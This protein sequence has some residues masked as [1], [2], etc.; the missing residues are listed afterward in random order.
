[1]PHPSALAVEH[2]D[3]LAR[4]GV[5]H[6]EAALSSRAARAATAGGPRPAVPLLGKPRWPPP[7]FA[8]ASGVGSILPWPAG[9]AGVAGG[10]A[11]T[12]PAGP[13]SSAEPSA[14]MVFGIRLLDAIVWPLS[15]ALPTSVIS[16]PEP[17]R[18]AEPVA[19]LDHGVAAETASALVERPGAPRRQVYVALDGDE[20]GRQGAAAVA[21]AFRAVGAQVEVLD[22]GS[23][24]VTGPGGGDAVVWVIHTR[25]GVLLGLDALTGGTL[26]SAPLGPTERFIAPAISREH[27]SIGG[28]H[29]VTCFSA[30]WTEPAV[31]RPLPPRRAQARH[32]HGRDLRVRPPQRRS[33][34]D[35]RERRLLQAVQDEPPQEER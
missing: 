23:P 8:L 12:E 7:G 3:R 30:P 33:L 19:L 17:V 22:P 2:R 15:A 10:Q 18:A 9:A 16:L 27:L 29:R 25:A 35:L 20:A 26:W 11:D 28:Q 21:D 34:V 5:E 6:P 24:A 4:F 31:P 1:M 13:G 32:Q 14:P